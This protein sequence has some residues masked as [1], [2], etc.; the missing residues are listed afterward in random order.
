MRMCVLYIYEYIWL[1]HIYIYIYIY[2]QVLSHFRHQTI[3]KGGLK[4][5]AIQIFLSM[6]ALRLRYSLYW[7]LAFFF[8]A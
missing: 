5:A 1:K 4:M 3:K 7:M 8:K 6:R 2:M